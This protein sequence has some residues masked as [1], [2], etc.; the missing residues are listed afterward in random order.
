MDLGLTEWEVFQYST[1]HYGFAG[2]PILDGGLIGF[3]IYKA[4][5]P[6]F[7]YSNSICPLMLFYINIIKSMFLI[8]VL[9]LLSILFLVIRFFASILQAQNYSFSDESKHYSWFSF[10]MA[11]LTALIIICDARVFFFKNYNGQALS[12]TKEL[13]YLYG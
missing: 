12:N 8:A 7:N 10:D 9:A 5:E 11:F 6:V 4:L 3:F 13:W 1:Q 2:S